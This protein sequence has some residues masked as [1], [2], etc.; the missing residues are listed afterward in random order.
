[1]GD[2]SKLKRN[3]VSAT[4]LSG[5]CLAM[6]AFAAEPAN[7]PEPADTVMMEE[8]IVTATRR[9]TTLQDA[10]INITAVSSETLETQRLDDF[11][12]LAR[13]VPGITVTDAGPRGSGTLI[14]RGLSAN[15]PGATGSNTNNAVATYLGEVPMYLD[16]KLVDIDRVEVLLGPQ[17]TLYGVGTLAGAL[18]YIPKAPDTNDFSADVHA[19]G[20]ALSHSDSLGWSGDVAFNIPIL[21]DHVALRSVVA[22][23]EDPGFIDYAYAVKTPGVSLPQPNFND[24]GQVAANL[25]RRKDV[26]DEK[27][28]SLRNSLLFK[29]NDDYTA[30]LTHLYQITKTHGRQANGAGVLGTGKYEG[31]WRFL[32]PSNRKSDMVSLEL[33][34]KLFNFARVVSAT[35]F[36]EQK[37]TTQGDQTD[38]LLDLEYGY[39]L[40][41]S[42]AA[43]TRGGANYRQFNQ[44]VRIVSDHGGPINWIVGGFFNR[45]STKNF[46]YEITPGIPEFMGIYRPDNIEYASFTNSVT[47]EEAVFGEV[48]YQITPAWQ[49]T[50]GGRYF[51]YDARITGGTA[52]PLFQAYPTIRYRVRSG[53]TDDKGSVLKFN[54]S[55]KISDT[56]MTYLTVSEGY[57]I[58]GVNRVA[59]CVLPLPAGQNVCALP[60]ELFY[61]PDKTL[62]K[63]IGVRAN[64]FDRRLNVNLSAYHIDWKDVQVSSQTLNGAVGITANAANAVSKGVELSFQ[65]RATDRLT[66]SG[67][68]TY[69][70]AHLTEDV[71]ILVDGVYDAF[72][73][74]RLPGSAKNSGSLVANY[75]QPLVNNLDLVA[76][77]GVSYTGNVYSKTGLRGF[78]EKI[79]DYFLH[80]ASVGVQKDNWDLTLFADNLF[81]KYAVVAVGNDTSDIGQINGV[82]KRY[83]N[84]AVLR[85]R[86]VGVEFRVHY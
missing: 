73:G 12:D 56:L 32:E 29:L 54:T 8:L 36:T 48:G 81:D 59:P 40:F 20:Y 23:Y 10:P 58:G 79:P 86:S 51:K 55:Y 42:F 26:N 34:A 66:L 62:N 82:T 3:L 78:G 18:R 6:P 47:K 75:K 83:Y 46:S 61:G 43:Y 60:S 72:A 39:E 41:P 24:A 77:Y 27:T 71:P 13:Y 11:R 19:R 74:D 53:E 65:G 85:P 44:E 25:V 17:G 4:F 38:L 35:A 67:S 63:E 80:K 28:L 50:I 15:S 5:F 16:F 22:D 69:N 31:P 1:M 52:L 30:T 37:V 64:L 45:F 76:S 9:A 70:D 2:I 14:V 68:Y 7:T 49:A 57:R 33:N 21:K 84:K